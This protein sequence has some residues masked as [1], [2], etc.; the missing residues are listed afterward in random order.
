MM[1]VMLVLGVKN[2]LSG[3]SLP[4]VPVARSN[5]ANKTK[6]DIRERPCSK[7]LSGSYSGHHL[8]KES[9]SYAKS[10]SVWVLFFG[11]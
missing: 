11:L 1:V 5:T 9:V 10:K 6:R 7:W 2:F 3:T 4:P 8:N